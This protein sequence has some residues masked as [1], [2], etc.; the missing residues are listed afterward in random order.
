MGHCLDVTLCM[1]RH[2]FQYCWKYSL[3][4]KAYSL[5]FSLTISLNLYSFPLTNVVCQMFSFY[6]TTL[7][8]QRLY[9]S[10]QFDCFNFCIKNVEIYFTIFY[11][12]TYLSVII[13]GEQALKKNFWNYKWFRRNFSDKYFCKQF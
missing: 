10:F 8:F 13:N 7:L 3:E 2:Y 1:N 4:Q 12:I 5:L 9:S 6:A 11:F